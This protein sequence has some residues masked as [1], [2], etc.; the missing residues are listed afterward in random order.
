MRRAS[1]IA[2]QKNGFLLRCSGLREF[3]AKLSVIAAPLRGSLLLLAVLG[4]GTPGTDVVQTLR[5]SVFYACPP[6]P[7]AFGAHFAQNRAL[8]R[9]WRTRGLLTSVF[10]EWIAL[11]VPL[12]SKVSCFVVLSCVYVS[13]TIVNVDSM[14]KSRAQMCLFGTLARVL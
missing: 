12:T 11:R 14:S 6:A 4:P 5:F 10:V 3:G 9:V 2:A 1:G 8:P 13:K 7:R